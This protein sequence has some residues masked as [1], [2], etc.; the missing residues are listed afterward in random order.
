MEHGTRVAVWGRSVYECPKG[1]GAYT[2]CMHCP[3]VLRPDCR[4]FFWKRPRD[5]IAKS[6]YQNLCSATKVHLGACDFVRRRKKSC[7]VSQAY[8]TRIFC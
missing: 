3:S 8:T 5:L 1:N 4:D 6:L 7:D 2:L